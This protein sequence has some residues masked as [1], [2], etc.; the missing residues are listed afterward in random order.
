MKP[1]KVYRRA[2]ELIASGKNRYAC[3][4]IS[5]AS[6]SFRRIHE[7]QKYFQPENELPG[8]PWFGVFNSPKNQR[9]RE[10]ALYL[11]AEIAKELE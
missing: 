10:L 8:S 7:F 3:S 11:M 4:A 9:A 1:S 2:A 5:E 6:D